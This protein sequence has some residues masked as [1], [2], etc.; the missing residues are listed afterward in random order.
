[1][2]TQCENPHRENIFREEF[3]YFYS[4]YKSEEVLSEVN[5]DGN[6]YFSQSFNLNV[7]IYIHQFIVCE[8]LKMIIKFLGLLMISV[9]QINSVILQTFFN[10]FETEDI[11]PMSYQSN[12]YPVYENQNLNKYSTS[13]RND[14]DDEIIKGKLTCKNFWHYENDYTGQRVGIVTFPNPDFI[15]GNLRVTLSVG[16]QLP[17]VGFLNILSQFVCRKNKCQFSFFQIC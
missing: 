1:M 16:A 4:L 10:T 2:K 5:D 9:L 7:F 8:I 11:F 17:S 3:D 12:R 14:F 13:S 15:E 6:K